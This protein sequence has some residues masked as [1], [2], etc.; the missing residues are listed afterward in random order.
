MTDD[1]FAQPPAA[2]NNQRRRLLALVTGLSGAGKSTTLAA[3]EEIGFTVVN[4]LPLSLLD[5]LVA[6]GKRGD[7]HVALGIDVRAQD[8]NFEA[9]ERILRETLGCDGIDARLIFLECDDDV[10]VRHFSKTRRRHPLAG[11]RPVQDGLRLERQLIAPLR[12][13][14]D[15]VIDT[16]DETVHGLRQR[17]HNQFAGTAERRLSVFVISFSF[18]YGVPRQADLVFDVRFLRNPYYA[19]NLRAMSGLDRKVGA[20]IAEDPAFEP[21]F[22]RLTDMIGLLLP[23]YRAEGKSYLTIAFGCTGGRHRSVYLEQRAAGW[24][25]AHDWRRTV[26]HRDLS[27]DDQAIADSVPGNPG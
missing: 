18:G 24:L 4:N 1:D 19:D 25:E 15:P 11:E 23:R 14:A 9:M 8:F 12:R 16:S 5:D 3:L 27:R 7:R 17:L 6:L 2:G 10:L 26:N 20:Y 22:C 13:I 21:F